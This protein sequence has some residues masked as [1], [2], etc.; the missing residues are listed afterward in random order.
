[1][2][3]IRIVYKIAQGILKL[4]Q[5]RVATHLL[6]VHHWW[7]VMAGLSIREETTGGGVMTGL[8]IREETTG[9]GVMTGLSIRE[10]TTGGGVMTGL[11]IR[12]ETIHFVGIYWGGYDHYF[13]SAATSILVLLYLDALRLPVRR[14]YYG[15]FHF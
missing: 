10:E 9:G 8:S 13:F 2:A 15:H 4:L 11:S 1:M 3:T 7:C 5:L 14:V 6:G 12:E